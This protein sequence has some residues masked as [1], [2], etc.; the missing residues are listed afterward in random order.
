MTLPS[1]ISKKN[2]NALKHFPPLHTDDYRGFKQNFMEWMGAK[3]KKPIKGEG[4]SENA[5]RQTHYKIDEVFRYLD[6]HRGIRN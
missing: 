6:G 1:P 2:H 4:Y 3:G 5:I